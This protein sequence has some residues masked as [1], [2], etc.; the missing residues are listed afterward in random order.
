MIGASK[1]PDAQPRTGVKFKKMPSLALRG[2]KK[3][4]FFFGA[5]GVRPSAASW[6]NR[7]SKS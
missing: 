2:V 5:T 6:A 4:Y 7:A 1:H 3:N